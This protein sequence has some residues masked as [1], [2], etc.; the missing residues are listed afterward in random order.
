MPLNPFG[1]GAPGIGFLKKE[2]RTGKHF[3]GA[4]VP[5]RQPEKIT[6]QLEP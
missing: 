4:C 5:Y 2:S 6:S 1:P 3:R